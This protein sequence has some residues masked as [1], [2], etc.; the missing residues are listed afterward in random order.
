VVVKG[1]RPVAQEMIATAV[2]LT[3]VCVNLTQARVNLTQA[4]VNLTRRGRGCRADAADAGAFSRFTRSLFH[5][6]SSR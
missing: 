2:N 5:T 4:R 6:A 1:S 3:Q